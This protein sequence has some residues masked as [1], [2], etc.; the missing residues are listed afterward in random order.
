[1]NDRTLGLIKTIAYIA[2]FFIGLFLVVHGRTVPGW[3]GLYIMLV[4]FVM[5]LTLLYVYNRKYK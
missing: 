2:T 5:L 4:G 1:M 3:D